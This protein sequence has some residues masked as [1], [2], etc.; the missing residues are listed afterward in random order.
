M[1]APD[2]DDLEVDEMVARVE[3]LVQKIERDLDEGAYPPRIA[4]PALMDILVVQLCAC[5]DPEDAFL[6]FLADFLDQFRSGMKMLDDEPPS[7]G[8]SC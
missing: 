8:D 7:P 4:L 2:D 6:H 5:D 1:T 3:D